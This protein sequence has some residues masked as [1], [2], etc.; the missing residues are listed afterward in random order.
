MISNYY[1]RNHYLLHSV[2]RLRTAN[3]VQKVWCSNVDC[4][5]YCTPNFIRQ[6]PTTRFWY[7]RNASRVIRTRSFVATRCSCVTHIDLVTRHVGERLNRVRFKTL[8]REHNYN[9]TVPGVHEIC[10]RKWTFSINNIALG[11]SIGS[12]NMGLSDLLDSPLDSVCF[13]LFSFEAKYFWHTLFYPI[14]YKSH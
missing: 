2:E 10:T 6:H 5:T 3:H 13:D 11:S 1:S 9:W 14:I 4:I 7:F 8:A 12:L